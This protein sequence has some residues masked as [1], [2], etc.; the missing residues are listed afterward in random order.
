MNTLPS[1]IKSYLTDPLYKNSLY[2]LL[3]LIFGSFFG[4]IFWIIAAVIYPEEFIGINTALISSITLLAMLSYL[5]LDQSMIRFFPEGNKAKMFITS[6]LI[7]IITTILAGIIFLIGINIWS[8]ELSIINENIFIFFIFLLAASLMN[9]P[10]NAF[11]ALRQNKYYLFQSITM[12]IRVLLLFLTVSLGVLGIFYSYGISSI[13]TF[14]FSFY[15][16]YRFRMKSVKINKEII[17]IEFLKKS[18]HFSTGNY[19][20]G[21]FTLA[22]VYLLPII[23]LNTLG[24]EST[25]YYYIAY[26]IAS[27]LFMI[28]MAF[29]TS[30]FVEGSHGESLKKNTLKS[31][32]A[33]FSL[34]VPIALIL[35]FFGGFFLGLIGKGYIGGYGVLKAIAVASFFVAICQ[36]YFSIK[37]VQKDIKSIIL[38]SALIFILLIGLSYLLM[39]YY[40]I[41]GVGYAWIISYLAGNLIILINEL[42]NSSFK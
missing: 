5:G 10:S 28:P 4:F 8:P 16:V 31:F 33:I 1:K 18:F 23:V 35:Y 34:L 17:D 26:S 19:I 38:I 25:A 24:T 2:I 42:F 22:P 3:S 9:L 13:I 39:L 20:I 6:T 30:L 41:R 29:S 36:V 14:F 27:L 11:I 32:L 7:V 21:V 12:G 37:K 15:F 40:G